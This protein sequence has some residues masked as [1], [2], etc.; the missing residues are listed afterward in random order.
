VSKDVSK[1]ERQQMLNKAAQQRYRERKKAKALEL[2]QAVAVLQEKVDELDV[3]AAEK[4]ALKVGVNAGRRGVGSL[5]WPGYA[6]SAHTLS[7]PPTPHP[8][9]AVPR[10]RQR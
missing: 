1:A 5:T 2:E 10:P 3:V 7:T 6:A 4:E 9:V 8:S